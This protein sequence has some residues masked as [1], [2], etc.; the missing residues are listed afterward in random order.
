MFTAPA[1]AQSL[2]GRCRRTVQLVRVLGTREVRI[3]YR[4]SLLTVGW[5]II[6]PVVVLIVYG[7]VLTQ[8]F[9]VTSACA[10]YLVTAWTGLVIWTFFANATGGAVTSLVQSSDLLGKLYFPREAVPLASVVAALP[11]LALGTVTIFVVALFQGVTPGKMAIF[12]VLPMLVIVLWAAAIGIVVAVL[13]SFTRDTI[14]GV[15]LALRVGFFGTPVMYD[16]TF[17]PRSLQF[18][19]RLSPIAV[20][21]T[22][23]RNAVLCN[24]MP[25]MRL[26]GAHL[27]GGVIALLLAILYTRSV[28]SRI[29]DVI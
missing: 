28:E 7:L 5:M 26:L 9:S 29:V 16:Q 10:P 17:L 25:S 15:H 19:E 13:A 22:E 2:V 3:R 24:T 1:D 18:T 12:A 14:H 8:S 6:T 20:S 11:D 4:Q 23:M 27:A 21:I